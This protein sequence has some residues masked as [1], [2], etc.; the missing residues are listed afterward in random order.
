MRERCVV[1]VGEPLAQ[2]ANDSR[3]T[4]S[5]FARD[6]HHL[7]FALPGALPSVQ[8]QSDLGLTPNQRR[9]RPA[10]QRLEATLGPALANH[11]PGVHG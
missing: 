1:L 2:R 8:Q 7:A 4:N 3:L 11:A 5:R 6:Q 9:K 10:V